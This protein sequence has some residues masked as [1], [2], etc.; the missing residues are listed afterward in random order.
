MEI[1][2]LP[3]PIAGMVE[4][5]KLTDFSQQEGQAKN[6]SPGQQAAL[7]ALQDRFPR[8]EVQF[9]AL[10]SAPSH[11]MATG[12]TLTNAMGK[13]ADAY[14]SVRQF[15]NDH[16]ELFGHNGAALAESRVTRD[17]ITAHNGMRTV[18]WQQ[19]VD[20]V[21]LYNTVL[22]ANLTN[23]GA[24][25]TL[26]SHF[27]AD[28]TGS[29]HLDA[30]QRA[31]LM[32]QPPLDANKA[33]SLAAGNLG[34]EVA[35][36]Q[37]VAASQP[38]G[39]EKKQRFMAPGLS[40]T[41]AQLAWLPMRADSARLAWDVT[42][43]SVARSEMFRVLVDVETGE[44]LM[45]TSLTN[46]IS[47]AT[48]RVYAN[49]TSFLPPDSPAPQTP[50]PSSP[51]TAQASEIPRNLVTLQA[52]NTTASPNGWIND[53]NTETLGNNVDAH[54]DT[55]ANNSPDLPR[56][57]GGAGRTFD[58]PIN[59]ALSPS[60]YKEASVTHLFYMNNWIHDK[61]YELGFTESAGNFQTNN[62]GRGG[63]GNDAVQADAQDGSGVNNANFSTPSDGSPGRMQM[64]VWNASEP[65]RD[66]DFDNQIVIHEYGHG[67]SNRLVGGGV[68]IT[69]LQTRG[70][71]E[72]W[73]D[74]YAMALLATAGEDPD[75]VYPMSGFATYLS[76]GM[77]TNYYYGIRRYPYGTDI[78]KSPL[79][80]KDI[81]PT[82]ASPHT[83]VPLSP[84][85]GSSNSNPTSV[86]AQGEV[87]C[88]ALWEVRRN[89]VVKH[90]FPG[91]QLTLQLV[92]D[93]MKLAPVNPNFLQAR[94]A[95]IQAD[96]VN[97]GGANLVEIWAGF[98][99][100][101]MGANAY[102]PAS[103]TTTGV[104]ESFD[105]PDDLK[106]TSSQP[107]VSTGTHLAGPFTPSSFIYTL[108]NTGAAPLNWTAAKT[109]PWLDL[110]ATGGTLAPGASVPVTFSINASAITMAPGTYTDT[111]TFTNSGNAVVSTRNVTLTVNPYLTRAFYFPL[112]TNPYWSREGQWD[113]GTPTGVNL[114]P[115]SYPDPTSGATGSKVFGINHNGVYST[116]VGSF[117]YLTSGP[118]NLTGMTG[119]SVRFKRWSSASPQPFVYNTVDVSVDGVTWTTI[120]NNGSILI[121]ENAWSTVTYPL[122]SQ[123]DNQP[124]VYLRW[125]HRVGSTGTLARA[126]WNIDD[127]EILAG[128]T[129]PTLTA[130]ALTVSTPLDI[131]VAVTLAGADTNNPGGPLTFA[132]TGMPANGTLSGTVPNV[133]Y[134]PNAGF[135]GTD[136]FSFTVNNGTLTSAPAG[137]AITVLPGLADIV[138]EDSM[139]A[140]LTDG[141]SMLGFGNV[142]A[143]V[144]SVKRLT[145]KNVG[146]GPLDLGNVSVDGVHASEF[147]FGTFSDRDLNVGETAYLDVTFSPSSINAKS[148]SLHF[149]SN[150]P[151]ESPFDIALVGYGVNIGAPIMLAKDINRVANGLSASTPVVVGSQAFFSGTTTNEG[152]ELW[153]TDGTA[154]GTF[155]VK[156][157]TTGTSGSSLSGLTNFNGK[158]F[159]SA[160]TPGYGAEL[161]T[162]DGTSAGT[163]MFKDFY[164]GSSSSSPANFTVIGSTLFFTANDGINGTELWK[165]DGTYAG[166]NMV[167]NIASGSSSSSPANLCN[168]NGTLFFT[169]TDGVYGVELWKS[170]GTPS[171][172]S[173]VKDIILGSSSSMPTNLNALGNTLI[174]KVNAGSN[175]DELW[176]SDGTDGGTMLLKD[177]NPGGAS[178]SPFGF[179]SMGGALYFAAT[180]ANEGTELWTTDGTISGTNLVKDVYPG[181]LGSTPTNLTA[182]GGLLYFSAYDSTNGTKPWISDGTTA[183]TM[184]LRNIVPGSGISS[185]SLFTQVGSTVYFVANGGI[186]VNK[187]LWKTD[188]TGAGTVQVK[189]I[190]PGVN[191]SSPTSLVN[192][193][194]MLIFSANDGLNGQELWKSDGTSPGTVMIKDSQLGSNT[195]NVTSL[196]VVN[197]TVYF[198]ADDG[199]NGQELWKSNGTVTGTA[200]V[201]DI[202]TG[203]S[204][205]SPANFTNI[206]NTLFFTAFDSTNGTELR[207]SDGTSAGTVLVSNIAAGSTSSLPSLL[208]PVGTT[209]FFS[210]NDLTNGAE[211]W[212]SD[213]TATGT[214]MVLNINSTGAGIGSS[215]TNLIDF[216]GTL[217]FSANDGVNGQELWKSDGTLGGTMLV[218]D[219]YGGS[220]SSSPSNF[221][222]IG[223]MLFFTATTAANGT[224][225]WVTDGTPGGATLVSDIIAGTGSSSPSN[226]TVVGSTLYFSAFTLTYGTELWKSDG[227]FAGTVLVKNIQ[228]LGASSVPSSLSNIGGTLYFS[229]VTSSAG[230][231]LWKS[232][233]TDA[234]T[235]LVKDINAGSSFSN[236]A[237]IT[238]VNGIVYMRATTTAE[239]VELWKSDGTALGT[240]LVAD[241]MP[242][243][244]S[245]TPANLTAVGNLLFYTAQGPD[246]GASE[247]FVINTDPPTEIVVEQPALISLTSGA[248]TVDF[249]ISAVSGEPASKV[250]T[251]RNTGTQALLI[252]SINGDGADIGD[253]TFPD[254][255]GVSIPAAGTANFT[256]AFEPSSIG[257]KTAA[258]HINSNDSDENPFHIALTGTGMVAPEI[259]IEQPVGTVRT[260]GSGTVPF[261]ISG[262]GVPIVKTLT[263][264]NVGSSPL[265]LGAITIDGA[266]SSD[267]APAAPSGFIIEPEETA[268]LEVTFTPSAIGARGAVLHIAS[269][270][271][272]ESSYE[273]ILTGIGHAASG[274]LRLAQDINQTGASPGISSV[275]RM[276]TSIYFAANTSETG[277]ELWKSDGTAAGTVLVKDISA[278]IV[279]SAPSSFVVF[280][281]EL[282]FSASDGVNGRELWKS[283]GTEAG[284]VMV[285][286]IFSGISGSSPTGL[287]NL[288]GTLYFAASGSTTNGTELW[289][290]DGTAAGTVMVLN[291]NATSG[292]SS[293][294]TNLT[295]VGT[296]LFFRADNGIN[297]IE[298][299]K[300]DGTPGG[301]ALIK[302][303]YSGF[304]NANP[305]NLVAVGSTLFFTANDGV[306]GEELWRSD[307]TLL[308]TSLVKD[309]YAG[310]SSAFFS[311]VSTNTLVNAGGTLFFR[312]FTSASGY[313]LWKSDGTSAG[314]VQV[315]DIYPGVIS[316][317]PASMLAVGNE[318]Y[319]SAFDA[320]NGIELWKS[321]GTD[322]GTV[323]IKDI[324]PGAP[325][326]TPT[327]LSL[328]G[329]TVYFSAT[330]ASGGMELWK[331][332]GLSANTVQ[333]K[334]INPGSGSSSPGV[335]I[336]VGGLLVFIAND[337]ANG[338]ELWVSDGTGAG[339][340]LI[341]DIT[342]GSSSASPSNFRALNDTLLFTATDGVR[343]TELW[344]SDGLPGGTLLVKDIATGATS[345]M[346]AVPGVVIGSVLYFTGT[347]SLNG[348]ELWRS[349]GLPDGTV[350]VKDIYSGISSSTPSNFTRLGNTL[351]FT[352][353]DITNGTEL[354]KS[355]GTSAGTVLVANIN[356][357][358]NASS[359]PANLVDFNGTLFFTANDGT[360]GT[361]LWK[362]D[363]STGGTLLV[364]DINAGSASASPGN[365]KVIGSTLYFT[366]TTATNGTELWKSDGTTAG[367]VIVSDL[368]P[369]SSSSFPNFLTVI[370]ST[371]FLSASTSATGTELWKSDGTV[372]GT[373]LVKDIYPNTGG[374]FPSNLT[375]VNGMLY[376]NASDSTHGS[377][378]WK[379]DGTTAGTVFV[380]D[381]NSTASS[382]SLTNLM[383]VRGTLYFSATTASAGAE[384]WKSDGTDTGTVMVVDVRP[385][386]LSSSPT[387]LTLLG[388]KLFFSATGTDIGNELW[389]LDLD[390]LQ[391]T[392]E[393]PVGTLL[394]DG[395]IGR[396]FGSVAPGGTTI[397]TFT[398]RNNGAQTL[399]G[400]T[401]N[402]EG[403]NQADFSLGS[404]GAVSLAPGESTTFSVMFAPGAPGTRNAVI[405]LAN[406]DADTNPFDL[407]VSG[408]GLTRTEDWRLQNFGSASNSGNGAN[409]NDFDFDGMTNYLEFCLKTDPKQPSQSGQ[410]LIRNGTDLEFTYTRSKAAVL[411]GVIF[412]VEW[413]DDL[414]PSSWSII[415]VSELILSDDGDVQQVKVTLPTGTSGRRFVRLKASCN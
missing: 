108:T 89:L 61:L 297:G 82:Q 191:G 204:S 343:G 389:V 140:E 234:G 303:I 370:G 106:V 132:V 156:D 237:S 357:S 261:G 397:L 195:A 155:L 245:S 147:S 286:D 274:R 168:V 277:T 288:N 315:K 84:R 262:L 223:S 263:I 211:L 252:T 375:E 413:S 334:D 26:G 269:D 324:N 230:A 39:A 321:D 58:F 226:L 74:F 96:V 221:R 182:T 260:D 178:S 125:G 249:G 18:V 116:T 198:S 138:V 127:V 21:P 248:A 354:W 188:G 192:F 270:D 328:V 293:L 407:L 34:E 392:V 163:A 214:S 384:L 299:W 59:S 310:S 352:A 80:L 47:N 294:P 41:S 320:A 101:G 233:G 319:F 229:A 3:D 383:N 135:Y 194:G 278:G 265:N 118:I 390:F 29:T 400:L 103:S 36:E 349:D 406:N 348:Q 95:I 235:I 401:L 16:K 177:I 387:N 412:T 45:R 281:G 236:P 14:A 94:D 51:T 148:A 306:N 289:K 97:N 318:I 60:T 385:G 196:H 325:S 307:G 131:P 312:A 201:S 31:K 64:F 253:F 363:G 111:I 27:M 12:Q 333:V 56:P 339:T 313:E 380:K 136:T 98:S 8:V 149:L 167:A 268:M 215:L 247:L 19:Q 364:R 65:D 345:G 209:L 144:A 267:F 372:A 291:I 139:G 311:S 122:G 133:I 13:D 304:S 22:K 342:P 143:G 206:G 142:Q 151:D 62:F 193:A 7:K 120:W 81:D 159:F 25:V 402:K 326:S 63:N 38:E 305:A 134:T 316:S 309:I 49:P 4:R 327:N 72:G 403:V 394:S 330:N 199:V 360:N 296:T 130:N 180:T 48:Y 346:T 152:A 121:S 43:M 158:L 112:D 52:V 117:T 11:I 160:T 231:E 379:S 254:L 341:K 107:F 54:T 356:P 256:V 411:G 207:K 67:L 102:S 276:G 171:G 329:E 259:V 91:N 197:G 175:G 368:I 50:G 202:A 225:L 350:L 399:N 83:G 238:N 35:P 73:S 92:T 113:Y 179:V 377:E 275:L 6:P 381:I 162:S 239:G 99:K 145:I 362:S 71:G 314:T 32:A 337:E 283:D 46:D 75:G 78:G 1:K 414:T 290:S 396:D 172:T 386:L 15:V 109:Q 331:T 20:G 42:L 410:S 164:V 287:I 358:A 128:S 359:A 218:K 100:R 336:D 66:G 126:G 280:N 124:T 405:H 376:F 154:A 114:L 273:L 366:A 344:R 69:A 33:L 137:V 258:I 335:M 292:L 244:A 353:F 369:G 241:L 374:S 391:V 365:L 373:T 272:D 161:W 174:F 284:T 216:N 157:I 271:A 9:D 382:S 146:A 189:D 141:S 170:D 24:L 378:L 222:V 123:V 173:M 17:D 322:T 184:M 367:T 243:T 240:V 30:A 217:F 251:I 200:L 347:D 87:W 183:G 213:G 115:N 57:N 220:G 338:S 408:T 393:Q 68:G 166:T 176:K 186:G 264:R 332:D 300:S 187:K 153:R 308:G 398:V 351:Y 355:D 371:L 129:T 10:T 257:S 105:L 295:A 255:A 119:G 395:L 409:G 227:T 165:S 232:D 317:S 70:M 361:E 246:L 5:N 85:Y 53:G 110:S 323:L 210:A 37:V 150:D 250:F 208:T 242:G 282:Y 77:T 205:S 266:N 55:D 415:G 388:D 302:D 93:G 88:N 404:L 340:N 301:T 212:K 224:E 28:P 169:A 190:Y 285:K 203:S 90:G 44:V 298:L 76:S 228:P 23:D 185:P 40:D 2:T 86:H 79:T 104:T 279:S 181:T 219:I